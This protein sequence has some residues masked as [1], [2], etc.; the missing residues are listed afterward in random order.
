MLQRR[1]KHGPIGLDIGTAGIKMVQFAD[2]GGDPVLIAA[3]HCPLPWSAGD[4]RPPE[5]VIRQAIAE[6]LQRHKFQGRR[7][8]T[9]L[10]TGE[11]HMKNIRLPKMPPKEMEAAVEF[12]AQDR[13]G[14]GDRGAQ[15][16]H[17]VAGEVRHGNELKEEII[18]FAAL[19]SQVETRLDMLGSLKLEP[20]AIDVAPC[21]AARSFFRFLRRAEDVDAVNVFLDV[22]WRGTSIV[23]THGTKVSFLKM[24]EAG[25]QHFV[26]AIA[27]ALS[28]PHEQAADLRV[29]ILHEAAGRRATEQESV[30][31]DVRAA[32]TDAVRSVAERIAKDVQMCLRY[33]AVT[34]R[35]QRPQSLTLVGGEAREPSLM[36]IIAEGIDIPCT[37]GHPLR[38]VGRVGSVG[39]PDQRAFQPA[40]A[41]ACGLALRGSRWVGHAEPR[42]PLSGAVSP[43]ASAPAP[44][45]A[46]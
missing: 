27:K 2:Q 25:G 7:V 19:D 6:A 20:L 23:L 4:A 45:G 24:V 15:F 31:N 41:V 35:G 10:G 40:W 42:A 29:R 13:F 44:A 37:I 3:A 38:G 9:A 46:A 26:E 8:V 34:F 1:S 30:P 18:V 16:Q 22:G 21:A 32:A 14:F 39:L 43:P 5:E 36:P 33:F 17:I 11:F 28:I 12:E